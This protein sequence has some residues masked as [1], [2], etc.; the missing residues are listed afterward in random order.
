MKPKKTTRKEKARMALR[1]DLEETENS[2]LVE[3]AS[4]TMMTE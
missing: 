3:V 2:L 1:M 4:E